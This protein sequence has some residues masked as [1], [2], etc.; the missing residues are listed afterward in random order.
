MPFQWHTKSFPAFPL[1]A[2][3]NRWIKAG[4]SQRDGKH[5]VYFYTFLLK[6]WTPLATYAAISFWECIHC[7]VIL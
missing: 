7:V 2:Y 5:K 4:I 6:E 1:F 3:T